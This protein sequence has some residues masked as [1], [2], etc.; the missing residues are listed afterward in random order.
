MAST[1]TT[2]EQ[3]TPAPYGPPAGT[4][5]PESQAAPAAAMRVLLF[6]LGEQVYGCDIATVREIIPQRRPTR[7]PGAP[8]FV[9]G[10]INLRGTIV[11]VIDLARRLERSAGARPDG[12]YIMIEMGTKLVGIAVDD[13]MD[14][15]AL[16]ENEIEAATA[17]QTRGGVVHGMGRL[18][19][20]R[21]V[22]LLDVITLARQV[23]L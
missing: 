9:C 11:T 5:A 15:R 19:D 2:A 1:A 21:M 10:L 12:S 7:L 8:A 6:A 17:D 22:V 3:R 18:G 16:T 4:A 20:E 23:L 13:V 14:V